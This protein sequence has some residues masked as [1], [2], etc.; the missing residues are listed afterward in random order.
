[1]Y[2]NE[3]LNS[4]L[5]KNESYPNDTHMSRYGHIVISEIIFTINEKKELKPKYEEI[6]KSINEIGFENSANIYSIS[7]TSKNGLT[8]NYDLWHK[9]TMEFNTINTY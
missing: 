1:M 8:I 5:C 2:E 3:D 7:N 9:C 6:K 4:Y